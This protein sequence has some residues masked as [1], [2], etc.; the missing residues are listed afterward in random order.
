MFMLYE[1]IQ[2]QKELGEMSSFFFFF[3]F[4]ETK[5]K[6][7]FIKRGGQNGYYIFPRY[8]H[9]SYKYQNERKEKVYSK[10]NSRCQR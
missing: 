2:T 9:F 1:M 10:E 4:K 6:Y 7:L 5:K 8:K 3:F